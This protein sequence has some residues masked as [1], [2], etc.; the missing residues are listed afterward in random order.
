MSP[1][2]RVYRRGSQ[3]AKHVRWDINHNKGKTCKYKERSTTQ[4]K[5]RYKRWWSG[6]INS[7]C[8]ILVWHSRA[9]L[10]KSCMANVD[11]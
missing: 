3:W 2:K 5:K 9:A 1:I 6:M 7:S 4:T 8:L 11:Y 10:W